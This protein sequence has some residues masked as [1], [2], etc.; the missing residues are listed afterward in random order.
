MVQLCKALRDCCFAAGLRYQQGAALLA[1]PFISAAV[2]AVVHT[3]KLERAGQLLRWVG[4]PNILNSMACCQPASPLEQLE[5][6]CDHRQCFI[7][8]ATSSQT[9]EALGYLWRVADMLAAKP[10]FSA[11]G[12]AADLRDALSKEVKKDLDAMMQ[13]KKK[14]AP[15]VDRCTVDCCH[16]LPA[17]RMWSASPTATA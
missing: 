6:R 12:T 17:H 13:P 3:L 14:S 5:A 1:S 15:Q 7:G 9:G 8:L 10:D 16:C 2:K 4:S 11:R